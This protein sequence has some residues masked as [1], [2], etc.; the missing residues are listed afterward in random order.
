MPGD[1]PEEIAAKETAYAGLLATAHASGVACAADLFV[2]AFLL[3]KQPG[4]AIPTS[5]TLFDA[6]EGTRNAGDF[7]A[8]REAAFTGYKALHDRIGRERGWPPITKQAFLSEVEG[9]SQ[10]VGSAETVAQKIAATM[11]DLGLQRFSLK[12]SA[13]TTPHEYLMRSVEL[14]GTQVIPRVRD[15]LA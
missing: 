4:V 11:R 15:L 7:E 8:A 13:G 14:Y 3:P 1:R 6:L 2:G 10:Y 5:A 12:Y 9:G